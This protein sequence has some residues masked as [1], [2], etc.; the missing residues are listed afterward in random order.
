[1]SHYSL[2]STLLVLPLPLCRMM[3]CCIAIEAIPL[4]WYFMAVCGIRG[5]P[6]DLQGGLW[7]FF[8]SKLFFFKFTSSQF[9]FFEKQNK[10]F[11][12]HGI[13]PH[14]SSEYFFFFTLS[15]TN[16]LFLTFSWTIYFFAKQ[17]PHNP[18]QT[19]WSAPNVV[20]QSLCLGWLLR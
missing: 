18:L 6:L 13:K 3:V 19:Q 2:T 12:P 7:F 17:P 8:L 16:N 5:R 4:Q 9:F 10:M 14:K 11:F 15:R 20:S 1:M